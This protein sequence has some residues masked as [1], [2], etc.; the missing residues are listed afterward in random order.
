[1]TEQVSIK[2]LTF[3]SYNP[4]QISEQEFTKLQKSL[5]EFGWVEPVVINKD[6]TVIGGHMRLR[7]AQALGWT[8][9]PVVR[10]D[11]TKAKEKALNLA[12]NKIHG[13]W[14]DAKLA[15]LLYELKDLPEI[16]LTGFGQDEINA[17]L[18]EVS[19]NGE[20]PGLSKLAE[21]FLVPPFSVLDARQGYWN[22][23]KAFWRN[24]INDDGETREGLLSYGELTDGDKYGK[25]GM[26]SVS[27]LDPVLAELAVRWFCPPNGTTFDVFAG[28]TVFGY[29]SARLGHQFSGVELREEQATVNQKRLDKDKLPGT[30]Y[31]DDGENV[32]KHLKPESQD[33]F[34]SCPPYFD[35]EEYSDKPN[36]LSNMAYEE[37]DAKLGRCIAN[38]AQV[39]KPDRFAVIVYGDVRDKQGVYR[40]MVS[41]MIGHATAAGLNYY[42]EAILVTPVGTAAIRARQTFASRKM[43][44]T[45]QN[46]LVFYKG[47]PTKVKAHHLPV[48]ISDE[49]FL[50]ADAA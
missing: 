35:L 25:G 2:S 5:Q 30:Y 40:N 48:E 43:V 7:A 22:D 39:L 16:D 15:E 47:D 20:V 42:N 19:G 28:D 36:D 3:A 12:L 11:I 29:V 49:A 4:R 18:A 1:M 38:A 17:L 33:L 44:K 41:S 34:F 14:D 37:F 46:V 24:L 10:L 27:L 23:R 6:N 45:H 32:L 8:D 13:E 9:I 21:T 26:A 50:N 31:V